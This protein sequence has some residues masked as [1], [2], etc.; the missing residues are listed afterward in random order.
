MIEMYY[1]QIDLSF[2]LIFTDR[3]AGHVHFTDRSV[4]GAI[5]QIELQR[6]QIDVQLLT[7]FAHGSHPT[8]IELQNEYE[9][10]GF[11]QF[12]LHQQRSNCKTNDPNVSFA[13]RSA[14]HAL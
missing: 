10:C 6:T 7:R 9:K 1:L 13:D 14:T 4:S 2:S 5:S 12:D 11:S 3:S 8:Q